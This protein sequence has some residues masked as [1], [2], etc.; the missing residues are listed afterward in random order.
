MDKSLLDYC[1]TD[2][3]R[4]YFNAMLE[5]GSQTKTAA[6]IGTTRKAIEGAIRRVKARAA[7]MG[8]SPEHDMD[9]PCPEGFTIKGI[10]TNYDESG[11]VR[12]QWV[13][14][15]IDR[16]RS[17]ELL[18]DAVEAIVEPCKGLARPVKKPKITRK[19][20]MACYPI[21][22]PH[23]GLYSWEAETGAD[24]DVNIAEALLIE[25]MEELVDSVPPSDE[26]LILNLGDYFHMDD[27]SNQT[28]QSGNALDVDGRWAKVFQTGVKAHREMIAIALKKHRKVVVKSGIGNHDAQSI[29]CLMSM[30]EAYFEN[31]PRVEIHLPI[32]PF[33]Y[34]TFGKNLI[35]LH[36]GNGIKI[37]ELPM[38]M[39]ADKSKE[40]GEA[41]YRVFFRGHI[42]HKELKEYAGCLVESFRS[43]AAKD[44]WHNA[45][46]YRAGRAMEAII[47]N[48]D[49][50]EHGRRTVN[51]G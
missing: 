18:K 13:K 30:M 29:F 36:H 47:F 3:E 32:N 42:H 46:G 5:H 51:V 44:S 4:K 25:S 37:A 45:S 23:M 6:A 43:I 33:A 40:W 41:V 35:G 14:T 49:G 15:H 48:R 50:G 24:Y 9:K 2:I 21:A 12:Q 10:S 16:E 8:Y 31:E 34:H 28:K 1:L 27:S 7:K 19:D 26:C 22:E 38:I 17:M 39:A 11:N 20:L